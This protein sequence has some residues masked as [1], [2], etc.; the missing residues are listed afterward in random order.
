MKLVPTLSNT[1]GQLTGGI[2]GYEAA[3]SEPGRAGS[4][5]LGTKKA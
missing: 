1:S 4:L 5:F 2:F 3:T